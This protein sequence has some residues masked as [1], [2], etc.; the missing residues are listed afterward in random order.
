MPHSRPARSLVMR[1]AA[2][3]A[4]AVLAVAVPAGAAAG[5]PYQGSVVINGKVKAHALYYSTG[6]TVCVNLLN[7]P[8]VGAHAWVWI[9]AGYRTIGGVS[10]D[11]NDG[12]RVCTGLPYDLA[13]AHE[14][15]LSRMDINFCAGNGSCTTVSVGG[16]RL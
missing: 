5:D 7:A 13:Q 15:E 4:A 3:G 12:Y 1:A 14:G 9:T 6:D 10:D 16:L 11:R 2:L 8:N